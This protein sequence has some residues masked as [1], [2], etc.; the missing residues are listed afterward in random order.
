MGY[1]N[2]CYAVHEQ[3][4]LVQTLADHIG[5]RLL[6]HYQMEMQYDSIGMFAFNDDWGFRT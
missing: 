2:L 1:D 3:P 6:K 5:E 4:D